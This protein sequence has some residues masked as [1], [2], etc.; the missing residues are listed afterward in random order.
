MKKSP[1]KWIK[2]LFFGKKS[3]KS[4]TPKGRSQTADGKDHNEI[5]E[6]VP[7]SVRSPVIS[8]PISVSTDYTAKK[9]QPE[10][11]AN[12]DVKDSNLVISNG[13]HESFS[14][15]IES[16]VE[17]TVVEEVNYPVT[18]KED[19][20]ATKAQS[21]FRGYLARRAFRALKG[22]VR[23]QAVIRG[24]LVR[25]QAIATLKCTWSIVRLQTLVR[26]KKVSQVSDHQDVKV[27]KSFERTRSI[28]K[29]EA[30]ANAFIRKILSFTTTDKPLK[31]LFHLTDPNS[32]WTWLERWTFS[33]FWKSAALQITQRVRP[34]NSVRRNFGPRKAQSPSVQESSESELEKVKRSLRKVSSAPPQPSTN[35]PASV[36]VEE[37]GGHD[38]NLAFKSDVSLGEDISDVTMQSPIECKEEG[39]EQVKDVPVELSRGEDEN[40][41]DDN[42]SMTPDERVSAE[43]ERGSKKRA[44]FSARSEQ[45][46]N[47]VQSAPRL[48]S[49]MAATQSAKAKFCGH[50]SPRLGSDVNEK[51]ALT[52]R[53]SLPSAKPASPTPR[54]QRPIP[55]SNSKAGV[56]EKPAPAAWRR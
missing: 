10:N 51:A 4:R 14:E 11:G 19:L 35:G 47:G 5:N 25:R 53:H 29:V 1:G 37:N 26:G 41:K 34:K 3:S 15:K 21:A 44:S 23:L 22:I 48:P 13:E 7:F 39:L 28:I 52:R 56:K 55:P 2:T 38:I 17:A 45:V 36:A 49:Y 24:H 18:S 30:S 54:T 27:I 42:G 40:S 12:E 46:D 16:Q 6:G 31:V 50:D 33:K 8:D 9:P 32:A 20:A 43:N